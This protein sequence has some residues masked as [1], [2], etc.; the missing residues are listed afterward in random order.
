MAK[1]VPPTPTQ[2]AINTARSEIFAGVRVKDGR[3][4]RVLTSKEKSDLAVM[5]AVK[6][7]PEA[8]DITPLIPRGSYL[9]RMVM[10]FKNT[11]TSYALPLFQLIM[12][13]ASWLTQNGAVTLI[14]GLAPLRPILWT[15]ALAA[16]GSSKTLATERVAEAL[17]DEGAK[18]PVKMFPTG[19]TDAEWIISLLHNNGSFWFQ[20]EVGQFLQQVRTQ[21]NYA[22]I[23]PW[24]LDAYSHKTVANRL[25]SEQ[26]KLVIEDPHFTF[27]G[28]TVRETWKMNVDLPSMLDGLCQRFNYVMAEPRT[29]TDMFDHLLFFKGDECAHEQARLREMW[30]AL[31]SQPNSRGTYTL[32][33]EVLPYLESWW[34]GLRPSWGNSQLPGSFIRRIGYS[35]FS[36]LPVIQF[37]LGRARQP[38]DI[39]T[40]EIATKYAE[41]HMESALTMIREYDNGW[42]DQIRTVAEHRDRLKE[43][44]ASSVSARD[45]NRRLSAKVR[46]ELNSARIREV[47]NLLEQVEMPA[48]L[49]GPSCPN[50]AK[51][52]DQ[53][54]AR[55][56]A[57]KARQKQQELSRNQKRLE[58]LLK[59][60]RDQ[61]PA[62][63][64]VERDDTVRDSDYEVERMLNVIELP[65]VRSSR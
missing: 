24:M 10:H 15:I 59:A 56:S 45:I 64:G 61:E 1:K 41:F 9:E 44:G 38:I 53:L 12:V 29:D 21:S 6:E 14:P 42:A 23:K 3:Q 60:Y 49:L 34:H 31:C 46:A 48:D 28:L 16:S 40:A 37:L 33:N 25:K 20:D 30:F 13:A 58:R 52:A 62:E 32:D 39:E 22:R 4:T 19:C 2:K 63:N 7:R 65:R 57:H 26:E 54:F 50:D 36:Y 11:D 27:F 18:E 17:A 55:H 35:V 5:L 43:S 51:I 8:L 47:L